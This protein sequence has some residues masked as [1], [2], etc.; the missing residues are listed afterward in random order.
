MAKEKQTIA[1][2]E[3]ENMEQRNVARVQWAERGEKQNTVKEKQNTV[4]EKE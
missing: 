1:K 2:E 4:K 3:W